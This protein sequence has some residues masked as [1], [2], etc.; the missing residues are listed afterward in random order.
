MSEIY[1]TWFQALAGGLGTFLPR[2]RWG[3]YYIQKSRKQSQMFL[4]DWVY[5][6]LFVLPSNL[7]IHTPPYAGPKW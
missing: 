5:T 7:L 1:Y 4:W 6:Y 2:I 3:N